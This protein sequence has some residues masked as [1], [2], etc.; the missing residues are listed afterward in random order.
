MESARLWEEGMKMGK[1]VSFLVTTAVAALVVGQPAWAQAGQPTPGQ[2]PASAPPAERQ[3]GASPTTDGQ[4]EN[5]V[6]TGS[7]LRTGNVVSPAPVQIIDQEAIQREG[8]I[9]IQDAIQQNP[10]FG[11]PGNAR[12][13]SNGSREGTGKSVVGLRNAGEGATL[14]L[15]DGRRIVSNDLG[16]I[17]SGFVDR[18]EILTGGASSVYG[19]DALAGVVNF[20]FKKNYDGL[21]ANVQAGVSEEG[22]GEEY[23]ADL[24]FGRNFAD[25]RGNALFYVGWSE[26]G[27]VLN[28]DR[29][30]FG[31]GLTSKGLLDRTADRSDTNLVNAQNLFVGVP[32]FSAATPAGRFVTNGTGGNAFTVIDGVTRRQ[33]TDDYFNGAPFGAIA[34]PL[35]RF[36]TAAR[37]NFQLTPDLNLYAQGTYARTQSRSYNTSLVMQNS[38]G[39]SGVFNQSPYNIESFVNSAAG[40]ATRVRNPFVPDAIFNSARDTN[41]D[42]LRDIAFQRRQNEWGD[43]VN[44]QK[45]SAQQFTLGVEGDLGRFNYEAWY[46]YGLAKET[47]LTT[48]LINADRVAQALEVIPGPNGPQC[49]SALARSQGCLPLNLFA[50]EGTVSAEVVNYSRATS[51]RDVEQSL[52]D[53]SANISGPLFQILPAG[54]VQAL[55]GAQYRRDRSSTV[56]DPL[57]NAGRNGWQQQGNVVGAVSATEVYGELEV[58][59]LADQPFFYNLTLRG[60]ARASWYSQIDGAFIGYNGS[61]EWAPIRDVR[62]RGTYARSIRAP[63]ISQL[64]R[65]G[66]TALDQVNDP[67]LG[68]TLT[69]NTPTAINCRADPLVVAN[70]NANN[71]VF[72]LTPVDRGPSVTSI[73]TISPNLEEQYA[74]TYTAGVVINPVSIDA[75]RNVVL[76]ADFYHLFITNG[77]SAENVSNAAN[78]C[79]VQGFDEFCT[80]SRRAETGVFSVGSIETYRSVQRNTTGERLV[81]GLDFTGSYRTDLDN[82]G[83]NDT[84]LSFSFTWSHLLRSFTRSTEGAEKRDL[85]GELGTPT[86]PASGTISIDNDRFGFSVTG[87]YVP[88]YIVEQPTRNRLLLADGTEPPRDLFTIPSKFYTNAQARINFGERYQVF[89]GVRNL[90]DTKPFYV[91]NV[92]GNP[93]VYD[94]IG[95]R[96]YAGFRFTM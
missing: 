63:T 88:E 74:T 89:V 59:L 21:Q 2:P 68:V 36:G 51:T 16:F 82:I 28:G 5:I 42:G 18:V 8:F 93:Y 25:G 40:V 72:T 31:E 66:N 92:G 62:F 90:T 64:F 77:I 9:N 15:V 44:D 56:Y 53:L 39:A 57:M 84:R 85:R 24:T 80:F 55:V 94:P 65:P 46:S 20:I 26:Q 33:V 91:Y 32:Q 75:L 3:P 86:N 71:G 35:E 13:T 34:V 30:V 22:D 76:T 6:V 95:R 12:T 10:A 11:N 17:P 78:L 79:Y 50:G 67:C 69:T 54:P 60:A 61:A 83:L 58:P 19:S 29:P 7:R 23:Q 96:F 73:S 38:G 37:I 1:P 48:G 41:G 70:I 45:R 4:N 87:Q 52:Q 47:G 49:A 81:E 27:E 43:F 14:L